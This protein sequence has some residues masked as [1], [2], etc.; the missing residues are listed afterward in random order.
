MAKN[1]SG[2]RLRAAFLGAVLM[3]VSACQ[4]SIAEDP[5][6]Q[7]KLQDFSRAFIGERI[8]GKSAELKP[9]IG[10]PL[11][12]VM[13]SQS[14][15]EPKRQDM[16]IPDQATLEKMLSSLKASNKVI[17]SP[18]D[19]DEIEQYNQTLGAETRKT[20]AS[21]KTPMLYVSRSAFHTLDH[22]KT[23]DPEL[24]QSFQDQDGPYYVVES[25]VFELN[26]T[27]LKPEDVQHVKK[28]VI[29]HVLSQK[30]GDWKVYAEL[31][32]RGQDLIG[33]T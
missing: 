31:E 25:Q 28:S 14:M 17:F 21:S 32:Q 24:W 29:Y 4:T 27:G 11:T 30:S 13:Q 16:R 3:L 20:L 18:K 2:Q 9:K 12:R 15:G 22:L 33:H 7:E 26:F 5:G 6:Q 1:K 10:L 23:I 8:E 19:R